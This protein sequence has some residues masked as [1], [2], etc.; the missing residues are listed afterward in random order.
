MNEKFPSTPNSQD[1]LILGS[2]LEA[3]L[4]KCT[5]G[6]RCDLP[7]DKK[8][9]QKSE[10]VLFL[11]SLLK[12]SE[13]NQQILCALDSKGFRHF[14]PESKEKGL[15]TM[16][17]QIKSRINR[18]T[19]RRIF[20]EKFYGF[21]R[22]LTSDTPLR[23]ELALGD[24]VIKAVK[25]RGNKNLW[26]FASELAHPFSEKG[27]PLLD[28]LHRIPLLRWKVPSCSKIPKGFF[29]C[30]LDGPVQPL[31]ATMKTPEESWRLRCGCKWQFSLCLSC[32]GVFAS[33]II[34]RN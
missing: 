10:D 34:V 28:E 12:R 18:S 17:M 21:R 25:S 32:L 27:D 6:V 9:L 24:D 15:A 1:K 7:R 13:P 19:I 22:A 3:P 30:P 16:S 5:P 29:F 31:K 14:F 26:I 11:A 20:A 2:A 4:F 8:T 23:N 33:K